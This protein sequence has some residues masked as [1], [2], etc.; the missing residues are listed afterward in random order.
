M[1]I[2]EIKLNSFRN[3][4]EERVYFNE[5]SN[6]IKGK[7]GQ[8]KTNL[9][10]S[11]YILSMGKSFRTLKDDELIKFGEK[12]FSIKGLFI[13]DGEELSIEIRQKGKEKKII[14]DGVVKKKNADLLENVY[15]VVFSPDDLKIVEE[16][17]EIRRKFMDRELFM[18]KPL[19]YIELNKYLKALESK[20]KILKQEIINEELLDIYDDFIAEHGAKVMKYRASF[21]ETLDEVSRNIEETITDGEE[22]LKVFYDSNVKVKEKIDDQKEE[23]LISLKENRKRELI[24]RKTYAGPHRD[25]LKITSNGVDLR[26]YGS[27]GQQRTAALSLKLAELEMI[28]KET[29]EDAILLLDDVLSEL[30]EERQRKIINSFEKNQLFISAADF[31]DDY[32]KKFSN[33]AS[34]FVEE[35]NIKEEKILAV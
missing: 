11:I 7:N 13:K 20:K 17:P 9:L 1:Y 33:G 4:K 24:N 12:G 29:G 30:D 18:I 19:Y 35:G 23:I 14:I 34:F 25:D 22:E 26:K 10:E 6:I 21:V 32:L 15:V 8:G 27:R 2:K 3:Y 28:K 16:S 31:N 5:N